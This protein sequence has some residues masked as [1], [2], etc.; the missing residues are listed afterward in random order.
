M[1]LTRQQLKQII[2]EELEGVLGESDRPDLE[3]YKRA[4]NIADLKRQPDMTS[5]A[6]GDDL[7]QALDPDEHRAKRIA[8]LKQQLQAIEETPPH[9]AQYDIWAAA[10]KIRK[11]IAK[12]EGEVNETY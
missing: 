7:D 4:T 8:K 5:V 2:K 12:L 11:E 10:E 9:R 1:K 3:T 6:Q